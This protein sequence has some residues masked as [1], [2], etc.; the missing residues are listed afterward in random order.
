[1]EKLFITSLFFLLLSNASM[2]QILQKKMNTTTA[3]AKPITQ[4][5]NKQQ[6]S[7]KPPVMETKKNVAV[8]PVAK[9]ITFV[10]LDSKN[11]TFQKVMAKGNVDM[12]KFIKHFPPSKL[13]T[14]PDGSKSHV[15]VSATSN[16]SRWPDNLNNPAVKSKTTSNPD[17]CSCIVQTVSLSSNSTN[18][19]NNNFANNATYLLPGAVYYY[20]DLMNGKFKQITDTRYPIILTTDN[21]NID[22]D[23]YV[24]V[25][26]PNQVNLQDGVTKLK[27]RFTKDISQV[28]NG[29]FPYKVYESSNSSDMSLKIGADVTGYGFSA[30]ADY[31]RSTSSHDEKLTVDAYKDLFSIN[32]AVPTDSSF[33]GYF[34]TY[35]D[36]AHFPVIISSVHYGERVLANMQAKFK[37]Q[38]EAADLNA[39]YDGFI[40]KAEVALSY[41]SGSSSIENNINAYYVGGPS[42][43]TTLSFDKK[44][45]ESQL[46]NFFTN[47]TYQTTQPISY[48]LQ[49]LYGNPIAAVSATDNFAVPLCAFNS[50]MSLIA[51]DLSKPLTPKISPNSSYAYVKT[52]N[53]SGDNKDGDTHWSFGLID[54]NGNHIA[55][56]HDNSNNDLYN[57]GTTTGHLVLVSEKSAT[58][59]NFLTGG[60]IHL[61][62]APNG[63]DT[64]NIDEFTAFLNFI[65]PD[66]ITIKTQKL[67]W[68][69]IN[70]SEGKRDVDLGFKYNAGDN[71]FVMTDGGNDW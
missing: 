15:S 46:K 25:E 21:S 64:W 9:K 24:V 17:S 37:S 10:K 5:V 19:M 48:E 12:S 71:S 36:D 39:T 62:V 1:M 54:N 55:S 23:S 13:Y 69:H 4:P 47:V 45:L 22:G 27:Q 44:E 61:N 41:F 42:Q 34:K 8:T 52:A 28:A 67:T 20:D 66:G 57:S 35:P 6:Q 38:S 14:F 7:N 2:A 26:S 3:T 18:F 68:T 58:F 31:G 53:N 33:K 16:G 65:S 49:D 50:N 29:T 70:L 32:A 30:S 43:Y 60:R 11:P 63:H 59:G 56:F 51:A 40:A